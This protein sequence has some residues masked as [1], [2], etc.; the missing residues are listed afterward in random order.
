MDCSPC[1]CAAPCTTLA[2]PG[3][4]LCTVKNRSRGPACLGAEL[5]GLGME[6][7]TQLHIWKSALPSLSWPSW[8]CNGSVTAS[9][10]VKGC[11]PHGI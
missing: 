1:T 10:E 4:R 3:C 2:I 7:P 8:A 11:L 5:D 6:P 9:T